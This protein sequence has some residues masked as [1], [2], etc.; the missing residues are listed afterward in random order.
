MKDNVKQ[1]E[2]GYE[3]VWTKSDTYYSK[4]VGFNKP[5]KTNMLFHK[6]KNKSWFINEGNFKLNYIDTS[7]GQLFETTLKEGQTFDI[8]ALMP[9]SIHCLTP[10][11]SY[12]EVGDINDDEDTYYLTPRGEKVDNAAVK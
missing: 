9:V 6:V 2:F 12:T 4:I 3:V 5:A 10:G 7:S 8:P 1:T 11:G